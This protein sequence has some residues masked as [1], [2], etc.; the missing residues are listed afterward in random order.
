MTGEFWTL[1]YDSILHVQDILWML[2]PPRTLVSALIKIL[3][4][5]MYIDFC[6]SEKQALTDVICNETQFTYWGKMLHCCQFGKAAVCKVI[7]SSFYKLLVPIFKML[8]KNR[9]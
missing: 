3:Q 5:D 4:Q 6:A 8:Y 2:I 7:F 1:Q 9:N